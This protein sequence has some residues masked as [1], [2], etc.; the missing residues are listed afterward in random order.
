MRGFNDAMAMSTSLK[1]SI[2]AL[3]V[4]IA[5]IPSH[6]VKCSQTQLELIS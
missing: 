6:L 1:K 4:F 5:I 3:L 2:C